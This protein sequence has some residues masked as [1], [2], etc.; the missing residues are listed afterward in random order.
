VE[1]SKAPA[2]RLQLHHGSCQAQP[3]SHS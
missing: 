1:S 2:R 3:Q